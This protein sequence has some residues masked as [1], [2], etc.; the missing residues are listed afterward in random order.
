MII[1]QLTALGSFQN[2]WTLMATINVNDNYY[3]KKGGKIKGIKN[4]W[5]NCAR[6]FFYNI[7][8]YSFR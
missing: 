1:F 4:Q 2:M 7:F 8:I 5:E 3:L 6:Q